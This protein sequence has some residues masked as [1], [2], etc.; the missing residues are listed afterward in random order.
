MTFPAR[1]GVATSAAAAAGGRA[2][3]RVVAAGCCRWAPP[4]AGLAGSCCHGTATGVTGRLLSAIQGLWLRH[5]AISI[6]GF[7]VRSGSQ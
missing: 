4:S 3:S 6:I 7:Y 5:G 2:R 1:L